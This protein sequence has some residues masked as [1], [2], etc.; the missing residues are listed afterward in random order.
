M[1]K[2]HRRELGSRLRVLLI[3][4][5]KYQFQPEKQGSSWLGSIGEQRSELRDLLEQNPILQRE[6][7]QQAARVY[8]N[9]VQR[10]A[11]E[12]GLAT[13]TFPSENSYSSDQ[14]LDPCFFP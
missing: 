13:A 8:P 12:T 5:L 7:E 14:L 9:A 6:V 4:L 10:A 1:G 11:N 2:S 3:H